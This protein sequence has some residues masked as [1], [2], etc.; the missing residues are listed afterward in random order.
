M[1]DQGMKEIEDGHVPVCAVTCVLGL[2]MYSMLSAVDG[3]SSIAV[4]V[5]ESR[6]V[7]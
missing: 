6:I 4:P 1:N 3:D 7:G 2:L 5:Q